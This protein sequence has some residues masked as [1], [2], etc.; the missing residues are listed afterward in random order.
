MTPAERLLQ[1][2]GVTEPSEIDLEAIAYYV[3]A[4]V[5][6]RRLVGCEA[7]IIGNTD[8]AIISVNRSSSARRKR[9]SIEHELAH[10]CHHRGRTLACRADEYQ[11]QAAIAAE[12]VAN[13]YAGDLLMPRYLFD[14]AVQQHQ[15]LTL[16][17]VTALSDQFDTSFTATAIR[18]VEGNYFPA[19]A[20]CHSSA[21]REWFARAAAVPNRWF[22]RD[23]LDPDS[24]AFDVLHADKPADPNPRKIGADA[25]FDRRNAG[26]F[27]IYE[28]TTRTGL[29][30]Y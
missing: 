26:D 16:K 6:Y 27:T 4:R 10:W 3:G 20:V 15:K 21:G 30:G 7:C 2:L 23:E 29:T 11:P 22:P 9:F 24:L 13:A 1:E 28:Q 17:A 8:A 18:V 5:R 19:L 12:R 14:R 25:W